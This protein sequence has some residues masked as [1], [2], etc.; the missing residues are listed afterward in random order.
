MSKSDV[1]NV[2]S[3]PT[4]VEKA[5]KEKTEGKRV[6]L[7]HSFLLFWAADILTKLILLTRSKNLQLSATHPHPDV[8]L[9]D[10]CW[11]MKW[12]ENE[13]CLLEPHHT[14]SC[15]GDCKQDNAIEGKEKHQLCFNMCR[16][17][18]V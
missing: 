9:N 1:N 8:S 6:K 5:D 10:L 12:I 11:S 3:C 18:C 13:M 7:N 17:L 2:R 14:F 4:G 15:Q 16:K